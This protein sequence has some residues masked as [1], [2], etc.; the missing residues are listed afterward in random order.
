MKKQP[1]SKS[2]FIATATLIAWSVPTGNTERAIAANVYE[3]ANRSGAIAPRSKGVEIDPCIAE[4]SVF[5]ILMEDEPW[6]CSKRSIR[7]DQDDIPRFY[8]AHGWGDAGR[9]NQFRAKNLAASGHFQEALN[10]INLAVKAV[11][12]L[13]TK[14]CSMDSHNL[15]WYLMTRMKL[16]LATGQ[17]S[18]AV[19]DAERIASSNCT[20]PVSIC[21]LRNGITSRAKMFFATRL[22]DNT[23]KTF[24]G[25]YR[26]LL[27]LCEESEG[28]LG[29]ARKSFLAAARYFAMSGK[30][31]AM[32]VCLERANRNTSIKIS[33][34]DL[35]RPSINK[36]NIFRLL[37]FLIE[38]KNAF[39]EDKLKEALA[40]ESY[41][42]KSDKVWFKFRD[43]K[44][45]AFSITEVLSATQEDE[46][47]A[48]K[49]R[50]LFVRINTLECSL[51]REEC[52]EILPKDN[53]SLPISQL[54]ESTGALDSYKVP[55]GLLE[56]TWYKKGFESLYTLELF[57]NSI[58]RPMPGNTRWNP[59][60][61]Y[62]WQVKIEGLLEAKQI[63]EAKQ[64]A[65]EW[66]EKSKS[67]E[68]LRMQAKVHAAEGHFD[69]ALE[70]INKAIERE[71]SYGTAPQSSD[72]SIRNL[73][74]IEKVEYLLENHQNDDAAAFFD[75]I[76]PRPDLADEYLLR[77]KL[78]IA[79]K[80]YAKAIADL[81][82]ASCKYYYEFRIVKRD[83]SLKLI[84]DLTKHL[85]D[86][87]ER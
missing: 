29:R 56:L 61:E 66:L 60:T 69:L 47:R 20:F 81:K 77:A 21:F 32:E 16:F 25:Y 1:N 79:K 62:E 2:I 10:E 85:E 35:E 5:H 80:E 59:K 26:Y 45:T 34:K 30:D 40:A 73:L 22:K 8:C 15:N 3:A 31:K 33:A 51:T 71:Y 83:E 19:A 13:G 63:N 27:A 36:A 42:R 9:Q 14:R 24:D 50:K 65:D 54:Q 17:N 87:R 82:I 37:K 44:S 38:D 41:E 55:S 57:E 67:V 6:E 46:K 7:R 68:C 78:E 49:M 74:K 86:K 76:K 48:G 58:S 23:T 12:D 72:N 53:V 84:S 28:E 39:D 43:P 64:A 70:W 18:N 52:K 11:E 4:D 75:L